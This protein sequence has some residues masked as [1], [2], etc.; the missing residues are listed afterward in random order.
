MQT[1]QTRYYYDNKSPPRGT[2]S[3]IHSPSF[4]RSAQ[5]YGVVP[6]RGRIRIMYGL[7][8][9]LRR[10]AFFA[11]RLPA[12]RPRPLL[13]PIGWYTHRYNRVQEH[14]TYIISSFIGRETNYRRG[15]RN[16]DFHAAARGGGR[17]ELVMILTI[18]IVTGRT[19]H[20][21][22]VIFPRARIAWSRNLCSRSTRREPPT[23][24]SSGLVKVGDEGFDPFK[25]TWWHF[26]TFDDCCKWSCCPYSRATAPARPFSNSYT[27]FTFGYKAPL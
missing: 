1:N 3:C 13:P 25:H 21:L 4:R 11:G 26:F 6:I 12:R 23:G 2:S 19:V 8:L 16:L 10:G 5:R 20:L 9:Y 17:G 7:H 24:A 22:D 14:N 15:R 27:V 18:N